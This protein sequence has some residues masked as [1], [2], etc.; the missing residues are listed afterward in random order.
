MGLVLFG[1]TMGTKIF[2]FNN[3]EKYIYIHITKNVTFFLL[4]LFNYC[5]INLVLYR[6][7][8]YNKKKG[9]KK[10]LSWTKNI[11]QFVS[12]KALPEFQKYCISKV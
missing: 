11:L 5:L 1:N 9:K 12:V 3:L 10:A 8:L 4:F 2:N 7:G 6:I